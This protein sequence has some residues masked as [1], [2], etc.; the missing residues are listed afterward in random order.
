MKPPVLASFLQSINQLLTARLSWR[1]AFWIF[2]S[3]LAIEAIIL[4]PSIRRQKQDVLS[5]L[6]NVTSGKVTWILMTYPNASGEALLNYVEA[7]QENPMMQ[8]VI[9]G[10]AVYRS[11]G[12]LVGTFGEPP[13]LTPEAAQ[14]GETYFSQ[15]PERWR[16]DAVWKAPLADDDYLLIIRHDA[17]SMKLAVYGFIARMVATVMLLS[18]FVTLAT[19]FALGPTVLNPILKLQKD[20]LKAGKAIC[21]DQLEPD[22]QSAQLHRRD[23]LGQVINAFHEMFQ[24]ISAATNERKA[25][26]QEL[27]QTN[28]QMRLYLTEVDRVTAA[29]T[30]VEEG[31]FQSESL[32]PVVTRD[33]ELGRLARVF[34]HMVQDLQQREE[35]LKQQVVELQ[36]EIDQAKRSRQVAEIIQTD[37][38]QEL[39]SEVERLRGSES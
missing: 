38:F 11:N 10:G 25:A 39:Q 15:S 34:R 16:Y 20:L 14:R 3:I 19:M 7:L 36:I 21:E 28:E 33:D 29:A 24:Q 23:E 27:R 13:R 12:E 22:F 31:T 4:I 26:E 2:I 30:A 17:Q 5:Q 18:G 9:M 37:Y 32:D 8:A 1:V 6:E 35:N